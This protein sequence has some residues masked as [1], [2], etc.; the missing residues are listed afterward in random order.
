MPGCHDQF[1]GY[2]HGSK[3]LGV[4]ASMGA[5]QGTCRLY[6]GQKPV[7]DAL[8]WRSPGREPNSYQ[9]QWDRLIEAIRQDQPL[10][11]VVRGAEASLVTSMGRMAAHTGQVV[12]YQQ[13]L[14]CEHEFAPGL[15]QL[16]ADAPPPLTPNPDGTY[17]VPM[18][19]I[20]TQREYY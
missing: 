17:P 2:A 4:I 20:I 5:P 6:R 11:E 19:G 9:L 1:D 8:A 12:T 18:P 16:T 14:A 3:G 10:N 7:D 15:D 13:M